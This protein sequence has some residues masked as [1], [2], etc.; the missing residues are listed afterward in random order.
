MNEREIRELRTENDFLKSDS[1]LRQGSPVSDRFE[2]PVFIAP[3]GGYSPKRPANPEEG[4]QCSSPLRGVPTW[5][6]K[7]TRCPS[8]NR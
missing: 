2:S 8:K 4:W 3:T 1:V 6:L 5:I 7:R